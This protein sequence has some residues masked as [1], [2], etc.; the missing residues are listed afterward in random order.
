M[1]VSDDNVFTSF[2]LRYID[3][4]F[5]CQS[6]PEKLTIDLPHKKKP[7]NQHYFSNSIQLIKKDVIIIKST[8]YYAYPV[9][10]LWFVSPTVVELMLARK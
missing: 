10:L 1:F 4:I 6:Y 9:I 3:E 8:L 2:L 7:K 5:V